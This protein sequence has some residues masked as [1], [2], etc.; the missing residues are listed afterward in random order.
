[1]NLGAT[2]V[3][4]LA[5]GLLCLPLSAADG[6]PAELAALAAHHRAA[7]TLS[8]SFTF[9]VRPILDGEA[10]SEQPRTGSFAIRAAGGYSIVVREAAGGAVDRWLSDGRNRWEIS[11]LSPEDQ[12]DIRGPFGCDDGDA[13]YRRIVA[14][15]RLDL[16]TLAK[17]HLLSWAANASGST[18]TIRPQNPDQ[19]AKGP[20]VVAITIQL[21]TAGEPAVI[22]LDHT[23]GNRWHIVLITVKRDE[24]VEDRMF[25]P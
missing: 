21:T 13:D 23:D 18:L 22:D 25:Q 15:L 20:Q 6:P 12:A 8:G 3:Y 17:D 1:M 5:S 9:L 7:T 2:A 10:P 24:P 19:Q 16:E 11:Q 4:L 14:C